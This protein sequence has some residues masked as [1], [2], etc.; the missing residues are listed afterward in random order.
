MKKIFLP[1]FSPSLNTGFIFQ[2]HC[3][4]IYKKQTT[5]YYKTYKVSWRAKNMLVI[6]IAGKH[7]LLKKV[8][9]HNNGGIIYKVRPN[10]GPYTAAPGYKI[11]E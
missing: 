5:G 3:T 9:Y 6:Y 4:V 11:T 2:E 8:S 1:S 7:F 10:T